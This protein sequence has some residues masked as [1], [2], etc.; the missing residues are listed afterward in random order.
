MTI[1]GCTDSINFK[2]LKCCPHFSMIREKTKRLLIIIFL[3]LIVI[4]G[5][6]KTSPEEEPAVGDMPESPAGE[7]AV[8]R[9]AMV[10]NQIERR[11]VND[12]VVLKAMEEVPRHRFVPDHLRSSAY[13][14]SPLPIGYG[15]TISQPYIVALMS[16]LLEVE[17]GDK[18]LEVGT[19]SGYQAAVLSVM[20]AE[21]HTVEIIAELAERAGETLRELGYREVNVYNRDGFY[22]LEAA[23]PFDAII[24][25]AAAGSIP[26]PLIQQLKEGGRMLIPVGPPHTVQN[27]IL[28]EKDEEGMVST[29]NILSVRFVPLTRQEK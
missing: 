9:R 26:P 5:C 12:P 16:E 23:A 27:L 10:E 19:G 13:R 15:Q 17:P 28:A 20:N 7:M 6:G 8:K 14:D 29:R 11:G 2:G 25:T 1:K 24:V 22:G 21:V 3:G 18:V 4:P